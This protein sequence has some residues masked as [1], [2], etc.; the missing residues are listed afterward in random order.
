VY[1]FHVDHI[2]LPRAL[3]NP[4]GQV[5]WRAEGRPYGDVV[6]QQSIDPLSG[7]TVVTNLRLPGQYD[8]R[9]LQAGLGLA[10]PYY[11]WNRWYLPSIGRYLEPDPLAL[12][13]LF[14]GEF[15]PDW[16]NYASGNPLR[17]SDPFGLTDRYTECQN[18][19][20]DLPGPAKDECVKKCKDHIVKPVCKKAPAECCEMDFWGCM[21]EIE[22]GSD[23]SEAKM[24]A[25][26][27]A[28]AKCLKEC[29]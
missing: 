7:R 10:G 3:T 24:K 12:R 1:Y 22:P 2:G 26:Y 29:H 17:R 11:N 25:C 8:E 16:Y 20:K 6:E 9:L 21:Q 13:G 14:N 28:L 23:G 27:D 18:K 5:V 4:S 19:C 15:G